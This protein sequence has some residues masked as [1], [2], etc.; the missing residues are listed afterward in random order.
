MLLAALQNN[1]KLQQSDSIT[2]LFGT[3]KKHELRNI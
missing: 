3:P 2:E 1:S